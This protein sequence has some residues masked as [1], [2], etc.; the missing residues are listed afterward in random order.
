MPSGWVLVD[1]RKIKLRCIKSTFLGTLPLWNGEDP[2]RI[3]LKSRIQ[4]RIKVK[5]GC[6][7]GSISKG[8]GSATL[9]TGRDPTSE[10][11]TSTT[12]KVGFRTWKVSSKTGRLASRPGSLAARTGRLAARSKVSRQE[13]WQQEGRP[14]AKQEGWQGNRKVGCENFC[15]CFRFLRTGN[16]SI[17]IRPCNFFP[18]NRLLQ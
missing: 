6:G 3:K 16:P 4:I 2:D 9:V 1:D 8:S 11:G 5:A 17:Y 15:C 14:V 7:S 10:E 13:S 18:L 12:R